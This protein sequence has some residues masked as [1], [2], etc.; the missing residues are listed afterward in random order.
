MS[1]ACEHSI[2]N[3]PRHLRTCLKCGREVSGRWLRDPERE[4]T[5]AFRASKDPEFTESLVRFAQERAGDGQVRTLVSRN[6]HREVRE[7]LADS[8]NYLC[9]LSDQKAVRGDEGLN[10][11]ELACLS[12]VCEAWRWLHMGGDE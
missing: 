2:G 3:D 5:L 7:E 6:F 1:T 10:A 4:R 11:G 9:W 12:H 8:F